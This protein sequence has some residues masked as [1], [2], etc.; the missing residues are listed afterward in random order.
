MRLRP[1]VSFRQCDRGAVS[2]RNLSRLAEA[3]KMH[4][5]GSE[6]LTWG[7]CV[8]G[9]GSDHGSGVNGSSADTASAAVREVQAHQQQKTAAVA[10]DAPRRGRRAGREMQTQQQQK[11]VRRQ[12]P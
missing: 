1:Q 3:F 12:S 6:A 2:L 10:E 11:Q 9:A 4:A 5:R 8:Q 7:L